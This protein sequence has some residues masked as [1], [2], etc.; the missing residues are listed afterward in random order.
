VKAG[1]N[2]AWVC[3]LV[4][5]DENPLFVDANANGIDDAFEK[6]KRG[7]TLLAAN[8]TTTDRTALAAQWKSSQNAKPPAP[9][10]VLRP[11]PDTLANKPKG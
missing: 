2:G 8:A 7:G 11:L 6:E 3:G 1:A 4:L 9:L 5:A 10:T